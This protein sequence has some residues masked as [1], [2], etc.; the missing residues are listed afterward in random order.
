MEQPFPFKIGIIGAG[1]AGCTLGRILSLIGIEFTIF[2]GENS[3][4]VR[5]QGGSLDLRTRTGLAAVKAAG[6][7]EEFL[8]LAR[9]DGEALVVADKN[10]KKYLELKGGTSKSSGGRPE[11]DRRQLR[12]MLLS[13][14]P[15]GVIQW[16]R[17]LK[18]VS[19]DLT[20]HFEDGDE[21]GFDLIVGADGAWS[22]TR[23]LITDQLPHYTGIS[24][25]ELV[26]SDAASR[27]PDISAF[28]NRGSVFTFGDGRSMTAQQVGDGSIK[29]NTWS[30]REE[31]WVRESSP[32]KLDP[33][34]VK[35]SLARDYD[36]WALELQK[37][38]AAADEEHIGTR[39]LYMLP[40]GFNWHNKPGVT[41]IGDA[42]HL[43]SP[44]AGEGAN[45]AMADAMKL[46]EYIKGSTTRA[47]LFENVARFELDMFER[48]KPSQEL[49]DS[50]LK[51]W[52]FTP[53]APR[54]VI[55]RF[56]SG[57]VKQMEGAV[58]GA[59]ATPVIYFGYWLYK[60]SN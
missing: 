22:K 49:S 27:Y 28:V 24:G 25:T 8:K 54:S 47:S 36:G 4:Q 31:S 53:G 1:P 19:E 59:L 37:L 40:V 45:L 5:S 20:L 51:G 6:L 30:A 3:P 15:E 11:I 42:A 7:N 56:V 23:L 29:V 57:Q 50:N 35:R 13:S 34:I 32:D 17:R 10:M 33:K 58:V 52:F 39:A 55:E 12:S 46:A 41:V 2:E 60:M 48:A 14:L 43:M 16:G 44:F 38:L 26:I 9:Y 18:S 21:S